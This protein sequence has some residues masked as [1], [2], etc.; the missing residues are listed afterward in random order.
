M[1]LTKNTLVLS[2]MLAG[3]T[4]GGCS[5]AQKDSAQASKEE[6]AQKM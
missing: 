1:T 4:L 5:D 3:L 6:A 2:L